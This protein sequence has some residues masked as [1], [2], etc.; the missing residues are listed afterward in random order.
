MAKALREVLGD[1][2]GGGDEHDGM[3]FNILKGGLGVSSR[4]LGISK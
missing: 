1:E 2:G 3:A 4:M